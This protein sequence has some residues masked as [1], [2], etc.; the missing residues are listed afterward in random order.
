MD[1]GEPTDFEGSL[2]PQLFCLEKHQYGQDWHSGQSPSMRFNKFLV[3][4][5]PSN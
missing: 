2:R 4:L 5:I 3:L 1:A